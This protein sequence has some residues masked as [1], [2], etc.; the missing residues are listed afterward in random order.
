MTCR[1]TNYIIYFFYRINIDSSFVNFK[2]I[3]TKNT[4]SFGLIIRDDYTFY[5]RKLL[6]MLR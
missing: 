5:K 2:Y 4:S 6:N 1:P 3:N